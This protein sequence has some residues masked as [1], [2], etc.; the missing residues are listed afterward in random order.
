MSK[1]ID[2]DYREFLGDLK[3]RVRQ[4]QATA[5]RVVNREW[6]LLYWDIGAAIVEKQRIANWRD[7]VVERL[8]S[9]LRSEFDEIKGFSANNLWLMRQFYSTNS[10]SE[11]LEQLVQEFQGRGGSGRKRGQESK[12]R[13]TLRAVSVFDS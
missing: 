8:S 10:S 1:I 7:S 4:A 5:A 11:F 6:I 2:D 13:S 12:M 3:R 9:D